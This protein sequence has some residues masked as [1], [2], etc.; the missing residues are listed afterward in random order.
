MSSQYHTILITVAF[1]ESFEI[2]GVNPLTFSF[3]RLFW[4]GPLH[5][6]INFRINFLK[7]TSWS[8]GVDYFES[9]DQFGKYS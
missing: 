2:G 5:F 9:V 6:H 8:V 3:S 1:V 4:L 7:E